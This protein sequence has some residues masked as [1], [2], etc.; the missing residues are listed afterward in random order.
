MNFNIKVKTAQSGFHFD[1]TCGNMRYSHVK[2]NN[3]FLKH[4]Q[5]HTLSARKYYYY[6]I[7]IETSIIKHFQFFLVRISFWQKR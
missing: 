7:Y 5:A 1:I 4:A 3:I 2:N 6:S